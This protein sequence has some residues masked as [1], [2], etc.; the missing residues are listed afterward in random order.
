E[1]TWSPPCGGGL[2]MPYPL[3]P[4]A[5]ES[6]PLEQAAVKAWGELRP[7]RSR[8]GR[9]EV[10]H[11]RCDKAWKRTICRLVGSGPAGAAVIAKR[12]PRAQSVLERTLYE[13]VV[14]YLPV[15]TLRYYGCVEDPDGRSCW[16]FLED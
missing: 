12:C 9:V 5:P 3:D 15:P 16:L 11:G 2:S 7:G 6:D 1:R 14:P 4:T 8:P 13:E 10:L